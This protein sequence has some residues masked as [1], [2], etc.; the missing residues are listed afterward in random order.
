MLLADKRCDVNARTKS[1]YSAV[2]CAV[3]KRDD[4]NDQRYV[5]ICKMLL[6]HKGY[7]VKSEDALLTTVRW[8]HVPDNT[9]SQ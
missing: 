7:D 6:S 1:G 8:L 2:R 9:T 5:D 4:V 3:V